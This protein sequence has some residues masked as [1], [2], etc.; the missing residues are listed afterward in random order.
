MIGSRCPGP[1]CCTGCR[2]DDSAVAS[3][4]DDCLIPGAAVA[5]GAR[6]GWCARPPRRRP[7]PGQ[8]SRVRRPDP[9]R[10]HRRCRKNPSAAWGPTRRPPPSR[11]NSPAIAGVA[12]ARA[13]PRRGR[14][15]R[16]NQAGPGL[17]IGFGGVPD[18]HRSPAADPVA[19]PVASRV[20]TR[21][22]IVAAARRAEAHLL[23][24]DHLPDPGVPPIVMPSS[25]VFDIPIAHHYSHRP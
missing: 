5:V 14:S 3:T 9:A 1:L 10:G 24:T 18:A 19:D 2:S 22:G 4:V 23:T 25:A 15:W 17:L 11:P 16:A 20:P 8:G 21:L 7:H 6:A 12:P 13:R